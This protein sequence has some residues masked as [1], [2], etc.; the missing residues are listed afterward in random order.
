MYGT[1]IIYKMKKESNPVNPIKR[2]TPSHYLWAI[3]IARIYEVLPLICPDC[4]GQMKI[5]AFTWNRNFTFRYST[6]PVLY[7]KNRLLPKYSTTLANLPSRPFC[8]RQELHL[9]GKTIYRNPTLIC[10]RKISYRTMSLINVLAGKPFAC[11][12]APIS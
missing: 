8:Y 1:Q 6:Y 9:C 12:Y 11:F 4:G 5:I 3:L 2:K 10:P 7:G